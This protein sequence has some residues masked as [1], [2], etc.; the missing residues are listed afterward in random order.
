M[1]AYVDSIILSKKY[2]ITKLTSMIKSTHISI[3]SP[4]LKIYTNHSRYNFFPFKNDIDTNLN[5]IQIIHD[6]DNFII[7]MVNTKTKYTHKL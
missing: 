1:N 4:L 6:N 3:F 2:L 7:D 5:V